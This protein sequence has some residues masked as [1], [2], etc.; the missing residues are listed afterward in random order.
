[1]VNKKRELNV[2]LRDDLRSKLMGAPIAG[3][4]L[5]FDGSTRRARWI[6]GRKSPQFQIWFAGAWRNANSIDFEHTTTEG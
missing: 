6:G 4:L 3:G 5:I 1:M 2:R